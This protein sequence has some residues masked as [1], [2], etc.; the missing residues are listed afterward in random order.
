MAHWQQQFYN[1]LLASA[2]TTQTT[3]TNYDNGDNDRDDDWNKYGNDDE[4]VASTLF[5]LQ[6]NAL[7]IIC[8]LTDIEP[9]FYGRSESD[10][11]DRFWSSFWAAL[12]SSRGCNGDGNSGNFSG[13]YLRRGV[14]KQLQSMRTT[15]GQGSDYEGRNG[16]TPPPQCQLLSIP[17]FTAATA[18]CQRMA[19]MGSGYDG[20]IFDPIT[21]LIIM[22]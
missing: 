9:S 21:H 10:L 14:Q 18:S 3:M 8:D 1:P 6:N 7:R 4:N 22:E 16:D 11:W 13:V 15:P 20:P 17:L 2:V 19:M 5:L 12:S